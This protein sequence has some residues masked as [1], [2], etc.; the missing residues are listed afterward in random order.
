[1]PS[2][3]P[4][5]SSRRCTA[6]S[7]RSNW[8][9]VKSDSG[10]SETAKW[11][12]TPVHS[13]PGRLSASQTWAMAAGE[14]TSKPVRPMPVSSLRWQAR[15]LPVPA[16]RRLMSRAA[17]MSPMVCVQRRSARL[18]ARKAGLG[19]R[20]SMSAP[21][22]AWR[23]SAASSKQ[24]TAMYSAPSASSRRAMCIAPWP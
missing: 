9:S 12:N 17:S 10:S 16:R 19:A 15:R 11:V 4:E 23:R 2:E 21:T 3:R 22:P 6:A 8:A 20:T 24:L 14:E 13:S 7:K 1:M 5:T 18:P